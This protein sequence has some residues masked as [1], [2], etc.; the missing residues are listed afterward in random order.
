MMKKIIML[1]M[2]A[3]IFLSCAQNQNLTDEERE[4]WRR[5]KQRYDAGQR[6]GP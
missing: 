4:K 3:L 5:A 6:G 2:S 1:I